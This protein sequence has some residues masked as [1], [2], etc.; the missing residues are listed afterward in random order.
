MSANVKDTKM[1]KNLYLECAC[2]CKR[3]KDVEELVFCLKPTQMCK[4]VRV[5]K[6]KIMMAV[7]NKI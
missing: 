5:G 2:K 4:E 7:V 1:L 6:S 3:C